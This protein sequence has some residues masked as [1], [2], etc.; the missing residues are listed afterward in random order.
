MKKYFVLLATALLFASCTGNSTKKATA[1]QEA[2]N[3][4][5]QTEQTAAQP[6]AGVYEGTIPAADA[7]GI[8]TT[9][10]LKADKTFTLS[11]KF[12]DRDAAAELTE[13]NYLVEGDLL[14][15]TAQDGATTKYLL[16]DNTL[17]RLDAEGKPLEGET[18]AFYN[19]TRRAE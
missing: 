18:A 15:L 11:E 16:K 10:E 4:K 14:T 19:L 3:A 13:G 5:T 8:A 2:D 17:Q 9:L 1:N 12:I 7:P 6:V